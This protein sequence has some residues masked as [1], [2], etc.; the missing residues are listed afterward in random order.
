[1]IRASSGRAFVLFTS[2]QMLR[3]IAPRLS[4]TLPWPVLIQ[5]ESGSRDAILQQFREDTHSILCGTRSFW[6]GVDVPG[7]ALSLVIIDKMP[8]APPDD[9]LLEA[10][11]KRCEEKGGNG[12]FDIQLPEAIAILRQGAGRLIRSQDDRG[13]IAILDSRLYRKSYGRIVAKNL[14][15][16]PKTED[17]SDIRHF[18]AME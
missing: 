16:A 1:L 7:E 8:F 9:R 14:P 12:F 10:R 5:D 2:H 18:F 11:R 15:P 6:E 3:R 13:V 17:V 4:D